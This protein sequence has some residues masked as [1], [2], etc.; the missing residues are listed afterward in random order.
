MLIFFLSLHDI[1]DIIAHQWVFEFLQRI[2]LK[3]FK[4]QPIIS[5]PQ[6]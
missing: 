2:K 5:V 1:N 6:C 4:S 3:V